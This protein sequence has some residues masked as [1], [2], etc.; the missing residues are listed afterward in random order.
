MEKL[1]Q[2]YSLNNELE[3]DSLR[4]K[5]ELENREKEKKRIIE[6]GKKNQLTEDEYNDEISQVR[7]KI[8]ILNLNLN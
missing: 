7:D 1:L 8:P 6:M 4:I 2:R 5:T 3:G